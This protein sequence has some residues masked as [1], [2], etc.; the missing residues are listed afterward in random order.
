M[1]LLT[2]FILTHVRKVGSGRRQGHQS[3]IK[4]KIK[5]KLSR[6]SC[7]AEMQSGLKK[8]AILLLF[9]NFIDFFRLF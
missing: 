2:P 3:V 5:K 6:A 8:S 7:H 1:T 4:I 9:F